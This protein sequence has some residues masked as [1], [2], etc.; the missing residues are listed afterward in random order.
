MTR[1]HFSTPL[2]P[3][4]D[5][6]AKEIYLLQLDKVDINYYK[7]CFDRFLARASACNGRLMAGCRITI[8]F[9]IFLQQSVHFFQLRSHCRVNLLLH[10]IFSAPG[11]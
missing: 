8:A 9:L 11:H 10:N 2:P 4:S 6:V 7:V 5:K 3:I 1:P